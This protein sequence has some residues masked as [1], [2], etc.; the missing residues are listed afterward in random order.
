MPSHLPSSEHP[1]TIQRDGNRP[2][3]VVNGTKIWV[4]YRQRLGNIIETTQDE[5]DEPV[6]EEVVGL[7]K[8]LPTEEEYTEV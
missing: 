2:R 7:V 6:N 4:A 8:D 1:S 5:S 3:H